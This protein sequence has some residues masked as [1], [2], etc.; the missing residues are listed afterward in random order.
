MKKIIIFGGY[1]FVGSN[2]YNELKKENR[3]FRYTS[4][5][6]LS[7]NKIK[8]NYLNFLKIIKKN[9]T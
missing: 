3:V 1:G 9:L 4:L 5:Q 8:Y 6:K 2:L 7:K